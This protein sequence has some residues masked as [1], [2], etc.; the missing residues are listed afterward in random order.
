M[1]CA[2]VRGPT[3]DHKLVL[4]RSVA[5]LLGPVHDIRCLSAGRGVY[6][7]QPRSQSQSQSQ[8]QNPA[9]RPDLL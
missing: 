7:W 4:Y 8:L 5:E 9:H 6:Q 3:T 2:L 1:L